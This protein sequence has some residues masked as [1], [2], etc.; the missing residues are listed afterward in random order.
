[1]TDVGEAVSA[2]HI[3]GIGQPREAEVQA[4]KQKKN[5]PPKAHQKSKERQAVLRQHIGFL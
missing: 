1:M 5:L 4:L 3:S 2:S